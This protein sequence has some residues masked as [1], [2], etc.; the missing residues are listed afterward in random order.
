V[1]RGAWPSGVDGRA[2][3]PRVT[4]IVAWLAGS[5]GLSRRDIV[6]LL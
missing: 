3:G 6:D 5:F 1:T 2:F 4:A